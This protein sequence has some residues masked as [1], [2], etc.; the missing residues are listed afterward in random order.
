MSNGAKSLIEYE[1]LHS[2]WCSMRFHFINSRSQLLLGPS[3]YEWM[4]DKTRQTADGVS[5]GSRFRRAK[6]RE[7]G[8]I[9]NVTRQTI[10]AGTPSVHF[11]II[12]VERFAAIYN[13]NSLRR[14]TLSAD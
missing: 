7:S 13:S 9:C 1:K 14:Q 12:G 6:P 4:D 5:N 11:N 2:D 3:L 10:I 8:I